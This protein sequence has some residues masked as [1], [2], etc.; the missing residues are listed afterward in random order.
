MLMLLTTRS[1]WLLVDLYTLAAMSI[2]MF[3]KH[4]HV[5]QCKQKALWLL[6]KKLQ[7]WRAR[8]RNP[9]LKQSCVLYI[10]GV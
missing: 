5:V 4:T 6:C 10:N 3:C 2:T 9:T 7:W 1:H 8:G